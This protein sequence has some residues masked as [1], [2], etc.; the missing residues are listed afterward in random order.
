MIATIRRALAGTAAAVCFAAS[1]A[2]NAGGVFYQSDFDPVDF[3]VKAIFNVDSVSGSQCLDSDGFVFANSLDGL[4]SPGRQCDV[5]LYSAVGTLTDGVETRYL[6]FVTPANPVTNLILGIYVEGHE[7]AG[8]LWDPSVLL[9]PIQTTGY[10]PLDGTW[11]LSFISTDV[12]G[13]PFDST[14]VLWEQDQHLR[15]V[16]IPFVGRRCWTVTT[17]EPEYTAQLIYTRDPMEIGYRPLGEDPPTIAEDGEAILRGNDV[18]EPGSLALLGG[19]LVAG[20]VTRRRKR[21]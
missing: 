12:N 13:P 2:A 21:A 4:N 1:F 18:P 15:C 7:L 9:G 20:W 8:I 10:A 11:K 19:A 3:I 17:W 6:P 14:A 5:S 16:T